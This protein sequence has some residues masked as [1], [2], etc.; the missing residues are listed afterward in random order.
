MSRKGRASSS[1]WARYDESVHAAKSAYGPQVG[2]RCVYW[3]TSAG[4]KQPVVVDFELYALT[5]PQAF[6]AVSGAAFLQ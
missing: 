1:A 3:Y 4:N 2:D 6:R 5:G